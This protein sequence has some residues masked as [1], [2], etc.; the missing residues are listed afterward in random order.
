VLLDE[1]EEDIDP[2]GRREV[3][4]VLLVSAVCV[5]EAREH[6]DDAF[7][8]RTIA[9]SR[10]KAQARFCRCKRWALEVSGTAES[11]I[12]PGNLPNSPEF[13]V[14]KNDANGR[15]VSRHSLEE[16]LRLS[17]VIA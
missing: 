15:R 9:H 14:R 2:L 12:V 3:R 4:V 13:T 16:C 8:L 1:V 6:L 10:G 11:L 17:A 7:H 5:S